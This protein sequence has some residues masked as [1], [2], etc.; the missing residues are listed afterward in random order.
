M[1][2]VLWG[3]TVVRESMHASATETGAKRKAQASFSF[4]T[5]SSNEILHRNPVY[6]P[7]KTEVE[8]EELGSGGPPTPV[9]GAPSSVSLKHLWGSLRTLRIAGLKSLI[10]L[11]IPLSRRLE[12]GSDSSKGCPLLST[13]LMLLGPSWPEGL[14]SNFIQL[15][16]QQ[17]F[18]CP[19]F[20]FGGCWSKGKKLQLYRFIQSRDLR[21]RHGNY[22]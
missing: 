19:D 13:V 14:C 4:R 11:N 9:P 20:P 21:Y 17:D 2:K 5:L 22:T 1:K 8:S 10:S 15:F 12:R 7:D 6:Y 3:Q 16:F 18:Y